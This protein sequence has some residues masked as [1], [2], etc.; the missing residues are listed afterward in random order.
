M[1]CS[2]NPFIQKFIWA[3]V[4]NI[5]FTLDVTYEIEVDGNKSF[6]IIK[7]NDNEKILFDRL[8]GKIENRILD[9]INIAIGA[10]L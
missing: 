7:L 5:D 1:K 6:G 3:S 8:C 9:K 2:S 4:K 10:S